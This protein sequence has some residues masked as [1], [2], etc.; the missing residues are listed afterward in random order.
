MDNANIF[1]LAHTCY[2][3]YTWDSHGAVLVDAVAAPGQF[4][5]VLV[6]S[7]TFLNIDKVGAPLIGHCRGGFH[8]LL[9]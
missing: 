8:A 1:V 7:C 6:S 4:V 9:L 3:L 2:V 5:D